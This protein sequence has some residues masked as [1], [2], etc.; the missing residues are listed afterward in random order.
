MVTLRYRS[1]NEERLQLHHLA[2]TCGYSNPLSSTAYR[3]PI[4]IHS[5]W[6]ITWGDRK[7]RWPVLT[8]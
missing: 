3:Y 6:M 5:M 4:V 8:S 2:A 1:G 7:G